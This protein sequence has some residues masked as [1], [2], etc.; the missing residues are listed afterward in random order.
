MLLQES[1]G[2]TVSPKCLSFLVSQTHT[3]WILSGLNKPVKATFT[4]GRE[5]W[6]E[7]ERGVGGEAF[8]APASL[9]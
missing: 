8:A 1:L 3:S 4:S 2:E 6:E 5:W 9:V 7:E